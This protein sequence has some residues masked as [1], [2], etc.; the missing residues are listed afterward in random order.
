[1]MAAYVHGNLP[2]ER[3]RSGENQSSDFHLSNRLIN[4]KSGTMQ[5]KIKQNKNKN[6]K[7]NMVT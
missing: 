7:Q 2:I 6:V 4:L 3:I 1:M 5:R